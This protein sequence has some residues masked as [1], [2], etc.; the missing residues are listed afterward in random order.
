MRKGFTLLELLIVIIII[1]ILAIFALPAMF[2]SVTRAKEA[3]AAHLL[4]EARNAQQMLVGTGGAAATDFPITV[5]VNGAQAVRV[6]APTG[7]YKKGTVTG[8]CITVLK[9]GC[10]ACR[11]ASI[12]VATGA[13]SWANTCA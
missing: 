11:D 7:D 5:M 2:D 1:G 8:A 9:D 10:A 6:D 4:G 3:K 12:N 13:I